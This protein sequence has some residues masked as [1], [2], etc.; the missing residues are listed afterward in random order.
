MSLSAR[1]PIGIFDSGVGGLTVL[2]ELHRQLPQES[3]VYF[4]DTARLPYGIRSKTEILQYVREINQ[5]LLTQDVKMIIMACNT[6]SALALEIVQKE[7][8][9]PMV[10]LI[11]PGAAVA[12]ASGK[13]I[14]IIAT[15]ATAK[16][17]AYRDA[18]QEINPQAVVWE[19]GCPEFVPLIE[20]N[21][22]EDPETEVI[23]R[24]YLQPLLDADIDT[25]VY[26]CTHYPHLAPVLNRLLPPTVRLVDPAVAVVKA[27]K[28]ELQLRGLQNSASALP[29]R[30]YVSGCPQT[31]AHNARCWLSNLVNVEKV[32]LQSASS[33]PLQVESV[34]SV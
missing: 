33:S 27:A 3:I 16:S 9:I 6:S 12:V 18:I 34:D 4:A 14:G 30:F 15:P 31:F 17:Q 11:L 13:R 8:D 25:L 22:V 28:Q 1:N 26:G 32:Y 24:K 21:R 2:R 29:T 19:V 7:F 23:V 5:W 10:G 20:Q